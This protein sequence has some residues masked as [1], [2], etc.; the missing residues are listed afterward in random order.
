MAAT[1]VTF[2]DM[3]KSK[4]HRATVTQSDLHYV[5]SITIDAALMEA[6]DLLPGEKVDVVDIDNG[7]RFSTYV[8]TGERDSGVIGVNGAAARLVAPGDLVIVISYSAV[9]EET[10]RSF[11]PRIVFVDAGNRIDA[12][13]ADPAGAPDGSGLVRGDT[14]VARS[15]ES[16]PATRT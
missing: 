1:P 5:G 6:A 3:L 11:Q 15:A 2:R 12:V 8:I 13:G 9:A 4:I 16:G 14:V 10:A 7:N